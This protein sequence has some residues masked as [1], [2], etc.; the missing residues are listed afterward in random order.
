LASG[1]TSP[2]W[3][4]KPP[5]VRRPQS[6]EPD[7]LRAIGVDASARARALP[8]EEISCGVPFVYVP[9]ASRAD[10]DR[11]DPDLAAL[12][13]LRSAFPDGHNAVFL[14]SVEPA[15]SDVTVYSRM[16][17]PVSASP[18]TRPPAAP[19]A[20]SAATWSGTSSCR[21]PPGPT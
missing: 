13:S 21:G 12:R 17:A 19:A 1:S 6:A 2:G 3:I 16:F 9:L 8:V 10:V 18:R 7:I 20:R 5:I 4:Q 14:F 11:A 15:G